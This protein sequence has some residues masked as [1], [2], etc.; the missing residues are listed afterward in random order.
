MASIPVLSQGSC[1]GGKTGRCPTLWAFCWFA[2]PRAVCTDATV[3]S[4]HT[5]GDGLR[6]AVCAGGSQARPSRVTGRAGGVDGAHVAGA[7]GVRGAR[8]PRAAV[9]LS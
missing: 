1:L 8:P 5:G 6:G 4:G 7:G 2:S 9:T 3:G